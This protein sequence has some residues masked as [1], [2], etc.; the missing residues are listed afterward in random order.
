MPKPPP[1]YVDMAGAIDQTGYCRKTI[2]E[3][4]TRGEIPGAIQRVRK[5]PWYFPVD[6]LREWLGIGDVTDRR[7]SA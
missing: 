5:S 7:V 4:A 1:G 2:S 3:A 6:G